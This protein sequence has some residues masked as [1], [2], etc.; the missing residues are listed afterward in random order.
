MLIPWATDAPI[1]HRP[2]ATIALMVVTSAVFVWTN[3][4]ED[5]LIEPYMLVHGEGLHPVQ[6]ITSN[7]LHAGF[8]HLA[9]NLVFLWAFALVVEGKVGF[10]PFLAIFLG[11][12]FLQCGLEQILMLATDAG[13]SLGNAA[14]VYGIMA[15]ALV[16]APQNELNCFW[17]LGFRGGL[18][19][20]S[21]LWFGLLYIVMEIFQVVFWGATFGVTASTAILHLSGAAVGFVV[22]TIML[23]LKWVDCENWDL[24]TVFGN[25]GGKSKGSSRRKARRSEAE[26][27]EP[28]PKRK[29]AESTPATSPEE[30]AAAATRRL[31]GHLEA[32]SAAEAYASYDKSVRTIA[33]WMPAD[34]D[35]LALIQALL[36]A[37]DWRTAVTVTEDYLR[38]STKPSA[39]VRL[40]LA[41]VLVKEFQRPAHALNVLDEIPAGALPEN[42]EAAANQLRRQAE[43]MR[44]DGVLELDGNA[45]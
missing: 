5:E 2:W 43:Q 39:R 4:L 28:R 18:I 26:E 27:H 37:Q 33:G 7:F 38:R 8:M 12:G 24:Y 31:K 35:W 19:D 45:W 17:N 6:W 1:Y 23:K 21:I 25:R 30:R 11:I 13:D 20:L 10:F 15:M 44:D 41:Q 40:R 14:I 16:W 3:G 42:L 29:A 36:T 32:G 34:A 22:A 9:G